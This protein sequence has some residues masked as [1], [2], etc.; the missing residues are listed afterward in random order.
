MSK[1]GKKSSRI[2][3]RFLF[4][5]SII[6]ILPLLVGIISY[7][8]SANII[9]KDTKNSNISMLHQSMEIMDRIIAETDRIAYQIAVNPQVIKFCYLSDFT[10]TS[11]Y[12][13]IWETLSYTRPYSTY[14]DAGSEYNIYFHKSDMVFNSNSAFH[15]SEYYKHFNYE[16]MDIDEFR[17]RFLNTYGKGSFIPAKTVNITEITTTGKKVSKYNVITYIKPMPTMTNSILNAMI[18]VQIKEDT[19]LKF[20]SGLDVSDDGFIY[21]LDENSNFITGIPNTVGENTLDD[22]DFKGS[23]GFVEKDINGKNMYITYTVSSYNNW[24]YVSAI[25]SNIVMAKVN[26]IRNLILEITIASI[27]V[28]IILLIL[29]SYANSKPIIE[30][31]KTLLDFFDTED[32][33]KKDEFYFLKASISDLIRQSSVM[34]SDIQ[35]QRSTL[36]K[37]VIERLLLG[38]NINLDILERAAQSGVELNAQAYTCV[39]ISMNNVQIENNQLQELNIGQIIHTETGQKG[40]LID[41]DQTTLCLLLCFN[42]QESQKC[43]QHT[44]TVISWLHNQIQQS[45]NIIPTFAIGSTYYEFSNIYRSYNEAKQAL[46]FISIRTPSTQL[47]Y[48][49]LEMDTKSSYYYPIEVEQRLIHLIKNGYKDD[50]SNLLSTVLQK[51]LESPVFLHKSQVL[52]RNEINGT[53]YKLNIDDAEN[54]VT[55]LDNCESLIEVFKY[56]GTIFNNLCDDVNEQKNNR[57][58]ELVEEIVSY[59]ESNYSDSNMSL[60]Q[61]A[62]KFNFSE[63]YIS[64]LF[65]E[66]TGE[67]FTVYLENIRLD[68]ACELLGR[69]SYT[70]NE[71]ALNSGYNSP[72]SFRR[73]FKRVKG[74]NPTDYKA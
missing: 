7:K 55:E 15:L 41:I 6:I 26:S 3:K 21:I 60:T 74:L 14:G 33:N 69:N 51:N 9:S 59:L 10:D 52:L 4:S 34:K 45:R 2:L 8:E 39:L 37:S 71:I 48:S 29:L 11:M 54:I 1:N 18:F 58:S 22:I 47:W 49:S 67:Y 25:P 42:T 50:V 40:Y 56:L 66:H 63:G 20:F 16:D 35:K 27:I 30:L 68:H 70:I 57:N 28:G 31:K 44:E 43:K 72:Q 36:Q 38:K 46:V 64:Q 19:I 62:L 24:K 17:Q 13:K 32:D 61:V 23:E 65:K 5:Y 73:A 53:I 12:F